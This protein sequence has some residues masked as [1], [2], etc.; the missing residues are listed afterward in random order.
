MLLGFWRTIVDI[1]TEITDLDRQ[2][3]NGNNSNGNSGPV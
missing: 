2:A 3:G 1:G